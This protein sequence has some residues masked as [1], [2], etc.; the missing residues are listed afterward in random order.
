MNPFAV[1]FGTADGSSEF[2][3]SARKDFRLAARVI[4]KAVRRA[5]SY[6]DTDRH[7]RLDNNTGPRNVVAVL[8]RARPKL[9]LK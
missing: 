4:A 1:V 6:R 7:G 2:C 3:G 5:A 8:A 9:G